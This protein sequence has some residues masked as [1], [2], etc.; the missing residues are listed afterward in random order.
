MFHFTLRGY[1]NMGSLKLAKLSFWH[2][3]LKHSWFHCRPPNE[4][5]LL[6]VYQSEWPRYFFSL[7]AT[8]YLRKFLLRNQGRLNASCHNFRWQVGMEQLDG[9][10]LVL[11][12]YNIYQPEVSPLVA[13]F[14]LELEMTSP[15]VLAG[16][17]WKYQNMFSM[18][19]SVPSAFDCML[20]PSGHACSVWLAPYV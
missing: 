12:S 14:L 13:W 1:L 5:S 3:V 16:Y 2:M 9:F 10:F 20:T 11:E 18:F 8:I 19:A 7:S 4:S 6:P 15:E 17:A